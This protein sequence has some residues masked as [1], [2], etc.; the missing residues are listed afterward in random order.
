MP[1]SDRAKSSKG[2]T[3]KEGFSTKRP[4]LKQDKFGKPMMGEVDDDE[5]EDALEE[6]EQ[7][8]TE[9]PKSRELHIEKYKLLRKLGE[10]GK[11]RASLQFSARELKDPFFGVKLAE[12]LEEEGR[13]QAALEWRRWVIQFD[14]EDPDSIRRLAGTAV[15]SGDFQTA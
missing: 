15:R 4:G 2:L 9:E 14:S 8:L 10:R 3:R 6:V 5:L 11:M 1:S 12:A 13:Y 7:K